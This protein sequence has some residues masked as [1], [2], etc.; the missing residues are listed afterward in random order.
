MVISFSNL[1]T[2]EQMEHSLE[3]L[4]TCISLYNTAQKVRHST[5]DTCSQVSISEVSLCLTIHAITQ[6]Q[7]ARGWCAV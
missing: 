7:A 3:T 5:G 6:L 1:E 2:A 4:S